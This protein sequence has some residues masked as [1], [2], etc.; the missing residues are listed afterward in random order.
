MT[1]GQEISAIVAFGKNLVDTAETY[2]MSAD[3]IVTS[4][5]RIT[6]MFDQNYE[7]DHGTEQEWRVIHVANGSFNDWY[8]IVLHLWEWQG[9][10]VVRFVGREEYEAERPIKQLK[11]DVAQ[12]IQDILA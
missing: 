11:D 1:F 3:L 7:C 2:F 12:L 5:G 8:R 9:Q 4:V 10:T 6:R